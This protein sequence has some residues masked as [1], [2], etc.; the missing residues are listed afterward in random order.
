MRFFQDPMDAEKGSLLGLA[1]T[2]EKSLAVL[3]LVFCL[4][5]GGSRVF[6]QTEEN[7]DVSGIGVPIRVESGDAEDGDVISLVDGEFR[8]S[9]KEFDPDVLGVVD[10]DA[11][12]S[13]ETPGTS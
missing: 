12:L 13:V 8:L 6:A 5:W 4:F 7:F 10:N 1:G 9:E 11:A 3:F 2:M